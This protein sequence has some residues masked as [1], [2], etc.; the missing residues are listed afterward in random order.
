MRY[1]SLLST[2]GT[3]YT[4][5]A[6][7]TSDTEHHRELRWRVVYQYFGLYLNVD[8]STVIQR[9]E[10]TGD[11]GKRKHPQGSGIARG[12]SGAEAPPLSSAPVG[13]VTVNLSLLSVSSLW[14]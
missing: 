9:F 8:V 6:T 3:W 11:V 4:A 10:E 1:V 7:M 12:G 14:I 13:G 2:L 5:N